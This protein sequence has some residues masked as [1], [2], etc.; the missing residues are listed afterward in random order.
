M[1]K[2]L[3]FSDVHLKVSPQDKPRHQEFVAFLQQFS[4]EEYDRIICLGDLFDFWFEYKHVIFSGYFEVLRTFADLRDKGIELHLIC[5]NHDFWGG[6]FLHD[7]LQFHIHHGIAEIPFGALR[8]HLV[9]GDGINPADWRYRGYKR[10]ARHPFVVGAFRLLHPD[11]AMKLAQGVSHGSRTFLGHD[12]PA[13]G[14]EARSLSAYAQAVLAQGQADVVMCGHAHAPVR[15]EYPTPG[16]AGLYINTGD[17]LGHRSH[18][19]WDGAGFEL[20]ITH[21]S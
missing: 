4:P 13:N 11:W 12:D 9:H 17:W 16:G 6:R 15:Q 1:K 20:V 14:P 10:V 18:V 19:V 8:G 2:T 21:S 7:D 3:I 5:G